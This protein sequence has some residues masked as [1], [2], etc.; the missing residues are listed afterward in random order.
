[1]ANYKL[2]WGETLRA[3]LDLQGEVGP[4]YG[5]SKEIKGDNNIQESSL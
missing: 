2:I 3:Q 4:A 1:M 5:M